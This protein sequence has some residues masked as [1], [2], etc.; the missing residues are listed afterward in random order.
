MGRFAQG[1][2]PRV[3]LL[4][5]LTLGAAPAC[6][7]S[8][9]PPA[10]APAFAVPASYGV[11]AGA[12]FRCYYLDDQENDGRDQVNALVAAGYCPARSVAYPMPLDWQERYWAYYSSPVYYNAYIPVAYRTHYTSVTVVHFSTTYKTQISKAESTARYKT[13][14]GT[15]VTGTSKVKF[16]SGSAVTSGHGG[17]SGRSGCSLDMTAVQDRSSSSGGH[18]GGSGRS[19][20]SGSAGKSSTTKSGGCR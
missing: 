11:Q 6:H 20:G 3:L 13:S 7:N 19:S 10:S 2:A 17:G 8:S 4:T 9:A 5:T 1:K 18:G 14:S 15:I 16:G 12:Q